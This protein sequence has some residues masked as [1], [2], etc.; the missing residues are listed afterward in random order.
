LLL[1]PIVPDLR[2]LT[3]FEEAW[4]PAGGDSSQP[5]QGRLR[6]STVFQFGGDLRPDPSPAFV[7]R[8]PIPLYWRGYVFDRYTG[9]QFELEKS[10]AVPHVSGE[11]L[12]SSYSD[13]RNLTITVAQNF[14]YLV[15]FPGVLFAAYEPRALQGIASFASTDSMVLL[16]AGPNREGASYGVV[17]SVVAP[18]PDVLRRTGVPE[19]PDPRYLQR[20]DGLPSR[21]GELARA[22]TQGLDNAFDKAVTLARYLRTLRYDI[23]ADAPPVGRD[24]VDYFLFDSQVGY[25]QHFAAAMVIMCRELGIPARVATGF[26]SGTFDAAEQSYKVLQLNYH[27]WVEVQFQGFG[28]VSFDPTRGG[29]GGPDVFDA[30]EVNAIMD[31]ALPY[32]GKIERR[33]TRVY[34]TGVPDYISG[35]ETF[36]IEGAVLQDSAEM[37]GVPR[38]PINVTLNVSGMDIFPVMV[39]PHDRLPILI[40]PAWTRSDGAFAA[41]CALPYGVAEVADS[42]S[43][44]VECLGDDLNHPSDASLSIPVRTKATMALEVVKGPQLVLVA[45]LFGPGGPMPGQEVQFF[46]DGQV[47]GAIVTNGSGMAGLPVK[48]EPG[49]HVFSAR[50][51]G[52]GTIGGASSTVEYYF[53]P[54]ERQEG[55]RG[56]IWAASLAA[57]GI[58]IAAVLVLLRRR[59]ARRRAR[60]MSDIYRQMLRIFAN[61]GWRRADSMTPYEYAFW[62]EQ[63]GVKGHREAASITRKFVESAY[64]GIQESSDD[65]A[66]SATM[67]GTI[68]EAVGRQGLGPDLIRRWV[69]S[70]MSFLFGLLPRRMP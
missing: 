41:L 24:V 42:V 40:A 66:G 35:D 53:P 9:R 23:G 45:T 64:A 61:A 47:I 57:V 15:T 59:V 33:P 11:I 27:A 51:A 25:C 58:S 49:T 62:L 21:V 69:G 65:I 54:S 32:Y 48:T 8:S 6:F 26:G 1:A 44:R 67:L 17:S 50:Y 39:I 52:D 31:G 3:G 4:R 14:T 55:Q 19:N 5:T 20:P 2:G 22:L 36:L 28:W 70:S 46:I 29:V 37:H 56:S 63:R 38:V 43:I 16:T 30:A 34:V 13:V 12:P 18:E 7:V 60:S 68:S 10:T